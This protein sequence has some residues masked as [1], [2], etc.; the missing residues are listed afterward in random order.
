MIVP[1]PY[2]MIKYKKSP[3]CRVLSR[4]YKLG[5]TRSDTYQLYNFLYSINKHN[6][7]DFSSE[8]FLSDDDNIYIW[9]YYDEIWHDEKTNKWMTSVHEGANAIE[10]EAFTKKLKEKIS[11]ENS[12]KK[13]YFLVQ[14]DI[15]TDNEFDLVLTDSD[16]MVYKD[17]KDL[18]SILTRK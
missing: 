8:E 1:S 17:I 16:F 14:E 4:K 7:I 18:G 3:Y 13:I 9:F 15:F 12:S 2:E 11:E 6:D 5:I 10:L